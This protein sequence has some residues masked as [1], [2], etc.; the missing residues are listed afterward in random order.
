MELHENTGMNEHTIKLIKGKQPPYRP[1][2]ALSL[3]ELKTLKAYIKTHLKTEFIQSSNSPAGAPIL[4][5]KKPNDS[6][7]LCV[8]Y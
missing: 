5:D 7:R 8:D 1:I 3:V 2:Y 6:L 4:F